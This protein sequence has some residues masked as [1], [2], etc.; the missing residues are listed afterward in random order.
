MSKRL[1]VAAETDNNAI[2]GAYCQ[3]VEDL[4]LMLIVLTY[5]LRHAPAALRR[6]AELLYEH[7]DQFAGL[8]LLRLIETDF[9]IVRETDVRYPDALLGYSTLDVQHL[10]QGGRLLL[11]RLTLRVNGD[12]IDAPV[13]FGICAAQ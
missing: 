13:L 1:C 7:R 8:T 12:A 5:E 2:L 10:V 4:S 11:G 3:L 6:V 9:Q